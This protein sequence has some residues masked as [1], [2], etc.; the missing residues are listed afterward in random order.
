MI[1]LESEVVS[2]YMSRMIIAHKQF[3]HT[4]HFTTTLGVGAFG[5]CHVLNN[6][7]TFPQMLKTVAT[8]S[9]Y[10]LIIYY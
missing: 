1:K 3:A 9:K 8:L 10:S 6:K 2:R 7:Q 5:S 4:W